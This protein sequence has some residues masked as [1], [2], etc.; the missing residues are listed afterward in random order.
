MKY[1]ILLNRIHRLPLSKAT[2]LMNEYQKNTGFKDFAEQQRVL[3][4]LTTKTNINS[5]VGED[6]F[7]EV[8]MCLA[9]MA[10]EKSSWSSDAFENIKEYPMFIWIEC[11][12]AMKTQDI[13]A[14]L[15]NYGRELPSALIETCI[16]N[17]PENMQLKAI[18]KYKDELQPEGELFSN[19]YYSVSEKSRMKLRDIFSDKIDD[20]ILLEIEDIDENEV[21]EKLLS[22]KSRLARLTPDELVEFML[23]KCNKIDTFNMFL[24]L[25]SKKIME[26]SIPKFELLI[27]RYRYLTKLTKSSFSHNEKEENSFLSDYDLF[28]L[29]K[30]KF[31]QIGI[32][33]TLRLFDN[34]SYY[35]NNDF[36]ENVILE[37]L[38]IAYSDSDILEYINDK[39]MTNII[40]RFVE[41]CNKKDYSLTDFEKL[42]NNI[43]KDGKDKLIHD[44][45]IEA[46]VACGKLLRKRE[47]N[48]Q[49][50]LF[51]ELRSKFTNDLIGRCEKDG[52]YAEYFPING[53]FYRL[54][55]GSIPF[56]KVYMTKTYKGLIYLARVGKSIENADYITT[57]LTDEQ[58]AKLN[59]N[60]A[61]RWMD[62]LNRTNTRADNLSFVERMGMQLLCYFGKD[63]GKYLLE[64][65]MRGNRMEN[66][67]DGLN[68]SDITIDDKGEPN[69]KE[70]L[71][72]YLFGKGMLKENNSVI[73][74]M[75]RGDIPEF[76][77]YFTEF[78]NSFEKVKKSCSG[79]LSVKRI[80]NHFEDNDLEI[81][82]KPDEI[83]FKPALREM[84]TTNNG[85]LSEAI[86]LC[87]CA[88]EREYSSIPKVEG[89]LGDFTYEILDLD[90]PKAVA[91]GY[92][93]HCCFV[94]R[95]ISYS[96][97]KHSMKSKNGR[98]FVVYYKG[99][100]LAQSWVWRNGDV[101]CFDSVEAGAPSHGMY[102]DNI[103]L[104]E[105]YKKAANE[106]L[107]ASEEA[108][109]DVE[110]IKVVTVGKSDYE[111]DNLEDV[112]GD[113]PRPLEK[114][115]HVYDSNKQQILAGIM[116]TEP[117]Y[118]EVSV[119]YKDSRKG[120]TVIAD[121]GD[122][123][124][125]ILDEAAVNINSLRYQIYGEGD[126]IDYNCYDEIFS[127]DGWYILVNKDGTVESGTLGKHKE[128]TDEYN[129]YLSRYSTSTSDN[130]ST[131][132]PHVKK[133]T[134]LNRKIGGKR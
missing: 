128:T 107:T 121:V 73:N 116:P 93:S 102:K 126:P 35:N 46:I 31:H 96:S 53:L 29:F 41:M 78:C 74:K 129:K 80:I 98:T 33:G 47:I 69:I 9:F 123:D 132:K 22:E 51:L 4:V 84:N 24:K 122:T 5:Q 97:L 55:K 1:A 17:L 119:K 36:T 12:G 70:E 118:G 37:F 67:F 111:F 114:N 103:K 30:E 130:Q 32:E 88:R 43:G 65:N 11:L 62:S 34:P 18:E 108:E 81:D 134:S 92:L 6:V 27:T 63:K 113:V 10:K 101:V 72:N 21:E 48:D 42:V 77:N 117:Q 23:L 100:F 64:S 90:D 66:L 8:L 109:D 54:A 20:D 133:I 68:Y 127:G 57:F 60:T 38:D 85:L 105:V 61:I 99:K 52:T 106:I 45:Y 3:D 76:E 87:K 49:N 82:L 125:D 59:I 56:D 40:N 13:M 19:F 71:I 89:Q 14:L 79:I 83:A 104:V 39:T 25:Y 50:P 124:V 75:I 120:V 26:S 91:V 112:G 110:R 7:M 2:K 28:C 86:E 44:D 15:N 94:V 58:L 95:G 16:I 115:V 131:E